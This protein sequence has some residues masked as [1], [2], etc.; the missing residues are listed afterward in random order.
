[1]KGAGGSTDLFDLA[2]VRS[3]QALFLA[4]ASIS[5]GSLWPKHSDMHQALHI[6]AQSPF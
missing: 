4:D 6:G 3:G 2:I 5:A 1:M